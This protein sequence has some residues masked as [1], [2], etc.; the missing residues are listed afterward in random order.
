[1][2]RVRKK[3]ADIDEALN[4]LVLFLSAAPGSIGYR[5]SSNDQAVLRN[6]DILCRNSFQ[7]K[8]TRVKVAGLGKS[9]GPR[10]IF[11][12]SDEIKIVRFLLI[13]RHQDVGEDVPDVDLNRYLREI[14][15]Y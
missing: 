12:V 6:L 11:L 15:D 1:L 8:K 14:L 3:H 9:G 5:Y 13:Y 10:L 2:K 7:T 4:K